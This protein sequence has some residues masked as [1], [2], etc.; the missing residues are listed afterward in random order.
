MEETF[1]NKCK[2]DTSGLTPQE[3]EILK[4]LFCGMPDK[5]IAS[6]MGISVNTVKFYKKGIL[7][8]KQVNYFYQI[9]AA[10]QIEI[11]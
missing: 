3:R 9:F 6:V 7:K 11:Y 2:I 1:V 10:H 8:K 4:W 5:H